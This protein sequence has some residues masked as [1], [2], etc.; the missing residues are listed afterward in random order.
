[1]GLLLKDRFRYVD[2]DGITPSSATLSAFLKCQMFIQEQ[3]KCLQK[4][5]KLSAIPNG[6]ASTSRRCCG[7]SDTASL[8]HQLLTLHSFLRTFLLSKRQRF[9]LSATWEQFLV[10][11]ASDVKISF[12]SCHRFLSRL[13]EA[14]KTDVAYLSMERNALD[15]QLQFLE[16]KQGFLVN[17]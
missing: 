1:M 7:G 16:V 10:I 6:V 11:T 13:K 17:H 12:L 4:H 3:F 8:L 5:N 14:L 15:D 9:L 2:G